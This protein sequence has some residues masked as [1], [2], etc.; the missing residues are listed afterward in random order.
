[1][2]FPTHLAG[3]YLA[4]RVGKL[5]AAWAVLGGALP[6]LVDK[7]LGAAGVTALYQSV[8]HSVFGLAAAVAVVA[9]A[10]GGVDRRLAAVAT[11]WGSHI[12]FDVAGIVL[13]GRPANWVLVAWPVTTKPSPLGLDPFAFYAQYVWSP[14]LCAEL[15]VWGV[16]GY[17]VWRSPGARRYVA[18]RVPGRGHSR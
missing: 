5:P 6:D 1:M 16:A 14:A 7:P 12:L 2:L 10:A 4:G 15:V 13:N 3:G 17:A 8:G 9:V 18:S 11:G